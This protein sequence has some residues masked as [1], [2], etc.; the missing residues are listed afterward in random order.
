MVRIYIT[1]IFFFF[2]KVAFLSFWLRYFQIS[3]LFPKDYKRFSSVHWKFCH[4]SPVS[5]TPSGLTI[6][7]CFEEA[8]SVFEISTHSVKFWLHKYH[9]IKYFSLCFLEHLF[10]FLSIFCSHPVICIPLISNL[11][12]YYKFLY[13]RH[14]F[15]SRS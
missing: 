1:L 4:N 12:N 15:P 8:G 3:I 14:H 2:L 9:K 6:V 7:W 10:C 5:P 11:L 13:S